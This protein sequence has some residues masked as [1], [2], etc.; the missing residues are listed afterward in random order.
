MRPLPGYARASGPTRPNHGL[1][2][3]VQEHAQSAKVGRG[4]LE[5]LF[6]SHPGIPGSAGRGVENGEREMSLVKAWA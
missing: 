3:V 4:C 5:Q 1:P 6:Q 2:L